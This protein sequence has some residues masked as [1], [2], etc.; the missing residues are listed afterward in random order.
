MNTYSYIKRIN[1]SEFKA[2]RQ[3]LKTA[4]LLFIFGVGISG[5]QLL[6]LGLSAAG[7]VNSS[8][9]IT[10]PYRAVF[11]VF[12][13]IILIFGITKNYF[14]RIGLA[15]VP[16]LLFWFLY[17]FRI[18]MDGYLSPTPLRIEAIEYI[19]KS[20]GITFIPMFIFLLRLGHNE[21]EIAFK[22]FWVVHLS[23][24]FFAIFYYRNYMGLSYRG[25][26]YTGVDTDVLMSAINLAYVGVVSTVISLQQYLMSI[27][28]KKYKRS[29]FF[30]FT[31][32]AGIVLI[33][34]SGTRSALIACIITSIIVLCN[35]I[36]KQNKIRQLLLIVAVVFT[37]GLLSYVLM[38]KF[39]AGMIKRYDT[40]IYELSMGDPNAG[41][42][43]LQIYSDTID[44][45]SE[46]PFFGSGLEE[47]H[48]GSY[49][50]NH[51]LE[52]FMA[53]GF[54]GGFCFIILCWQAIKRSLIILKGFRNYGWLACIFLIYFIR[55]LFS[56]SIIDTTLW[57]SMMAVYAVPV[58]GERL[59]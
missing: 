30:I 24:L 14:S 33:F 25:L 18:A 4:S 28:N 32:T 42:G 48:S 21:N 5:Y 49:P 2:K 57:F 43:R 8:R 29:L 10:V 31:F 35:S 17:F 46:K 13:F 53:T 7:M 58:K 44:Q 56:S 6:L 15:W 38:E 52:A 51:F 3:C 55:G 40:L 9:V 54:I 50:H 39:G 27:F 20:I 41:A 11:M 45:I 22:A 36:T 19:Q 23:C 12:S 1:I 37:I 34:F 59:I 16:L 47:K 26:R